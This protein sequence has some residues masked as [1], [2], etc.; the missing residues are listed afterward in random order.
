MPLKKPKLLFVTSRFPFPTDKGDK[1]R[2]FHQ[3]KQLAL[4]YD[5]YLFALSTEKVN[6]TSITTLNYYCKRIDIYYITKFIQ[7]VHLIR[8]L[9][10]RLPFQVNYFYSVKAEKQLQNLVK[11]ED[12]KLGYFQLIRTAIYA[13]H[14]GLDKKAID[15]MD[16]LSLGMERRK[17]RAP[18]YLKPIMQMEYKRLKKFESTISQAFHQAFVIAEKDHLA[19]LPISCPISVVA[20]GVDL[21]KTK[22]TTDKKYA[23]AFTGNMSYPPNIDAAV[24]LA[25]E[26]MPIVWK[27]KPNI[28]LVIAGTSPSVKVLALKSD[29][30]SVTGRV[31]NMAEYY[32]KSSIFVAPM[33]I[34]S[35]LQN[36]LL[37]AMSFEI[38]CIT[39][40]LANDALNAKPNEEI[41]VADTAE[42]L[43]NCILELLENQTL[44]Q[45]LSEKGFTFV[46]TKYSWETH[47]EPIINFF[48]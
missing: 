30:V 44:H 33:R 18:I 46:K 35:G 1:L 8:T 10:N 17:N 31:P 5:I 40:T 4:Y 27:R 19:I 47:T 45:Q 38:P 12:I 7:A 28:N 20:N 43:A 37:E 14:L 36:K 13:Q 2:A 32:L 39:S 21:P 3:I 48:K 26:I 11:Q 22:I 16:A 25:E 34:G 29:K 42:T 23:V 6:S 9:F 24:F 41:L 15:Y